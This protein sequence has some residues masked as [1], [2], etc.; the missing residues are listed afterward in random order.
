[1]TTVGPASAERAINRPSGHKGMYS[2]RLYDGVRYSN[3][4]ENFDTPAT[5]I[6]NT[7]SKLNQI[8]RWAENWNKHGAAK[9]RAAA[10]LHARHWIE[11]F[12]AD[13][14][15]ANQPWRK[16]HVVPDM[17]GDIVFEWSYGGRTLAAYVSAGEVEYL[18]VSG[19]DME[20][21]MVEG[22]IETREDNQH[23]WDWL[24]GES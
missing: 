21:D 16:P 24:M 10:L 14:F 3:V 12:R 6:M 18:L 8:S 19:P 7:L 23:I 2:V 13:V 17:D 4:F 11:E 15:A 5:D 1:M 9:P 22:V 20:K